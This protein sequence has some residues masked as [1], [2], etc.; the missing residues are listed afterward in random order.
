[1]PVMVEKD[2]AQLLEEFK[3][4]EVVCVY[5]PG[6]K[7]ALDSDGVP[8]GS[9]DETSPYAHADYLPFVAEVLR[10]GIMPNPN[11]FVPALIVKTL[12]GE[13]LTVFSEQCR[14]CERDGT[15]VK[16]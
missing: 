10:C 16:T 7:T 15:L 5:G 14:R 4:G 12:T 2:M 1:M 11:M 3:G 9:P 6:V 13:V 8:S